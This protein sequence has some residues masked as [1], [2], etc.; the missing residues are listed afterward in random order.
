MTGALDLVLADPDALPEA[1]FPSYLATFNA[2]LAQGELAAVDSTGAEYL[3]TDSSASVLDDGASVAVT[4][5]FP[6]LAEIAGFI[7]GDSAEYLQLAF[8]FD[9]TAR[10][11]AGV[12]GL[13]LLKS[14]A[15][16]AE[17]QSALTTGLGF[18]GALCCENEGV[19]LVGGLASDP[20]APPLLAVMVDAQGNRFPA[21]LPLA[22][23]RQ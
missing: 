7:T 12:Q 3:L 1:A 16:T 14:N 11:G 6:A 2:Q 23:P 9:T 15:V 8:G 18:V 17:E 22:L 13:A 21:A 20:T 10:E 19:T 5:R 4:L